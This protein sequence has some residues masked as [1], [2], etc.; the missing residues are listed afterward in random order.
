[1]NQIYMELVTKQIIFVVVAVIVLAV[2]GVLIYIPIKKYSSANE[3]K[4]K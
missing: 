4:T 2:I 1:M 3:D